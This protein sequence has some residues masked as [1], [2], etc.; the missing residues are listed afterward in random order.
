MRLMIVCHKKVLPVPPWPWTKIKL[1][2]FWRT[3]ATTESYII[4]CPLL[5]RGRFNECWLLRSAR[6]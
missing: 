3:T 6:S 5:R 4:L 2:F 1:C